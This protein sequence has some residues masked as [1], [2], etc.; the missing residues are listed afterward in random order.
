MIIL[1]FHIIYCCNN[2]DHDTLQRYIITIFAKRV[3]TVVNAVRY[4][5]IGARTVIVKFAEG[6]TKKNKIIEK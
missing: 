5:G 3:W 4:D 6:D 2:R 1:S